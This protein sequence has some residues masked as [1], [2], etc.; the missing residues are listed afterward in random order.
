ML[1]KFYKLITTLQILSKSAPPGSHFSGVLL[2]FISWQ[3]YKRFTR[4]SIDFDLLPGLKIRCYADSSSASSVIYYGLYEYDMMNFLLNYLRDDD[5]FID[6]GA[7]I[8]VYSLLASSIIKSGEIYALEPIP[9]NYSRLVENLKLNNITNAMAYPL[10]AFSSQRVVTMDLA[11]ED[12]MASITTKKSASS[13][14]VQ[15]NTL[16]GLFA[17]KLNHTILIKLDAEGAELDILR[18]ATNLMTS[19][20][21][22]VWLIDYY[23]KDVA[24]YLASFGF[25]FYKFNAVNNKVFKIS[26]DLEQEHASFAVHKNCISFM[27]NRMLGY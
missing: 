2:R 22:P 13:V 6:I 23:T 9:K 7:N 14:Q 21:P 15:T 18:G 17:S 25:S 16:D 27:E 12:C 11:D 1:S 5:I 24:Q 3:I 4:Q 20:T 10:A 26:Q 8:G 19:P